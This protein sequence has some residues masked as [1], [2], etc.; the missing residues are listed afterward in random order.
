MQ[1][2]F[3]KAFTLAEILIT[4]GIIGIV[5]EM[6][7]PGVI[8]NTEK[9]VNATKV[10]QVYSMISQATKSIETDCGGDITFCLANSGAAVDNDAARSEV[11]NLY[12]AKF[13]IAKDCTDGVIKECFANKYF[14]LSN[15]T[16]FGNFNTNP[17]L[18]NTN[19]IINNGMTIGFKW[20]GNSFS[21]RY[22]MFFVDINNA[23]LPNQWGKDTFLFYYDKNKKIV[24]TPTEYIANCVSSSTGTS[25][26]AKII[27]EGAINYY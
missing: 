26:S 10:K 14:D 19:F 16:D 4:I 21:D 27:Q 17:E 25:C 23:K 15:L 20:T 7:M 22:Y 6:V 13:S 18:A 8:A 12:K 5:A 24:R 1:N 11:A 3:I 2:K 9:Q